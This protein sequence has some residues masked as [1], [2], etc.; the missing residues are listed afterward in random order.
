MKMQTNI[1]LFIASMLCMAALVTACDDDTN[2]LGSEMMPI[3][4]LVSKESKI[5]DV[6]TESYSAGDSVLART[7]MSYIGRFTDPETG[8]II[9]SDFLAQFH[10]IEDFAFPDSVVDDNITSAEIRLYVNNFIGDSLTSFKLN[11]YPLN[12]VMNPDQD[13]YTNIDPLQYC[14]I[15]AAPIAEKWYTLSDR[16][17]QDESRWKSDYYNNIR[18]PLPREIGQAIYDLYRKSPETFS[19]SETWINSGLVGSKGFYFKLESGDG[20]L[21]YIDIAQLILNFRY[22]DQELEKDTVGT[23]QFAATEEVIQATRFENSNL[24]KLLADKSA[25]YLKSPAGIFT[26]ATLP[27]EQLSKSDT[28]NTA[29]IMFTRYNDVVESGFKLSIPKTL[30]MVRL[31]D[32][33]N[34]YFEKYKVCDNYTSYLASFNSKT[35]T[36]E[37]NNI[38]H[39][40]NIMMEEKKNG[41]ATENYNKVLLIPVEPTYDSNTAATGSLVKLCHDFSMTSARLVGGESDK[42]KLEIIYSK[43]NK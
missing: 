3:T 6:N 20:A 30:L 13:Y 10:C 11:V 37:F 19:N 17:I 5:Y 41:T 1:K 14:D 4:D 43:F 32:Y 29:K 22:Y 28:I 31:D 40:L 39:I 33:L 9:K 35:N 15:N 23:C 16:T 24:D 42:V 2:T 36:Y 7:T 34:G 27:A 12:K 38:A 26:L 21:A 18:I 8:T 25:T